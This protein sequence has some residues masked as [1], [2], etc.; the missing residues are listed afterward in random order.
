[1]SDSLP[2]STVVR[3]KFDLLK[4]VENREPKSMPVRLKLEQ[5]VRAGLWLEKTRRQ[6]KGDTR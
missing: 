3:I 2:V 6:S 1:M 4:E 5:L